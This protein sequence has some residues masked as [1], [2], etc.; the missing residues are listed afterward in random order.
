MLDGVTAVPE[1]GPQPH[2]VAH[3][4]VLQGV[5]CLVPGV[6]TD[7]TC[8]EKMVILVAVWFIFFQIC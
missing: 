5:L 3:V 8:K 2:A 6:S 7:V 1:L 4:L